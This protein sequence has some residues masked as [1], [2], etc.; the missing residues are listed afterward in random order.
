[1]RGGDIEVSAARADERTPTIPIEDAL[2]S[3][4]IETREI[5]MADL[6]LDPD[7][8]I[9]DVTDAGMVKRYSDAMRAGA[10]FPAI[11][12]A[13]LT[14]DGKT[15]GFVLID[16]WHRTMAAKAIGRGKIL[17]DVLDARPHEFRWLASCANMTNGLPLKRAEK[18]A[19]FKAYVAAK[20]HKNDKGRVKSAREI[21]RDLHG[22]PS[23]KTIATW[24]RQD[25]PAIYRQMM[26]GGLLED[27]AGP[28]KA[29]INARHVKLATDALEQFWV[30]FRSIRDPDMR[31][32]LLHSIAKVAEDTAMAV[33]GARELPEVAPEDF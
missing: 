9:R 25:F 8:Q 30:N 27:D 14:D 17:A 16:G 23:D 7:T 2:K 10:E 26:L 5:A 31:E 20:Q 15:R 28:E 33:T 13:P 1:M 22:S 32:K 6:V 24:M 18:R 29:D 3:T 11:R 12:V 4:V 21:S 19:V